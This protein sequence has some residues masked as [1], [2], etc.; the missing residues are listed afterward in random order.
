MWVGLENIKPPTHPTAKQYGCCHA[1]SR[2]C[3][4]K[5]AQKT[6]QRQ[7]PHCQHTTQQDKPHPP[8]TQRAPS[9]SIRRNS[10]KTFGF[11]TAPIIVYDLIETRRCAPPIT[12]KSLTGRKEAGKGRPTQTLAGLSRHLCGRPLTPHTHPSFSVAISKEQPNSQADSAA[13]GISLS[14]ILRLSKHRLR[15]FKAA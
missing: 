8:K 10:A 14:F 1:V 13:P 2:F 15:R 7:Q 6:A 9:Q 4:E 3:A 5:T 12:A 11:A